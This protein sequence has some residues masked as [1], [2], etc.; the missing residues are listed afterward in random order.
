MKL[1]VNLLSQKI[2]TSKTLEQELLKEK[3]KEE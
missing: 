2:E 1:A 3:D